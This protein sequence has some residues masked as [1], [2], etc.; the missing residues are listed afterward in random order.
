MCVC[1][2]ALPIVG[3]LF[4]TAIPVILCSYYYNKQAHT[5][6]AENCFHFSFSP[7]RMY[8]R[9]KNAPMHMMQCDMSECCVLLYRRN[10]IASI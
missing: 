6:L 2:R 5:L 10:S 7:H 9:G 8:G 3:I 4:A 1:V